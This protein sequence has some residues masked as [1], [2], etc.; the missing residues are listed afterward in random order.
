MNNGVGR[1][2]RRYP[3]GCGVP[4]SALVH[5]MFPPVDSRLVCVRAPC[6]SHETILVA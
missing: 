1:K 6:L 4:R 2:Q 3:P 5:V